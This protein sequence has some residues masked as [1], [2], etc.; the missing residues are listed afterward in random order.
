MGIDTPLRHKIPC[1]FLKEIISNCSSLKHSRAQDILF[2][3][4][5]PGKIIMYL[6]CAYLDF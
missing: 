4:L 6:K 3:F 5:V 1:D 2:V